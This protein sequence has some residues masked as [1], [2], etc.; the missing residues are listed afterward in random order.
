MGNDI[1]L[2]KKTKIIWDKDGNV[3][4]I[5]PD[6]SIT[7][8]NSIKCKIMSQEDLNKV[9]TW[10]EIDGVYR[11]TKIVFSSEIVNTALGEDVSIERTFTYQATDPYNLV[12][13]IDELVTV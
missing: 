9:F 1:D 13:V 2:K 11:V 12:S 8:H 7:V 5:N 4:K 6:G 10:A 3:L